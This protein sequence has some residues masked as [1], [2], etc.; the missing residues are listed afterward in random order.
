MVRAYIIT[1]IAKGQ[2]YR[3][4]KALQT[5]SEKREEVWKAKSQITDLSSS[6]Q[7]RAVMIPLAPPRALPL[8]SQMERKEPFA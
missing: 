5:K 2:S 4:A 3:R 6:I 7:A 1:A 8:D